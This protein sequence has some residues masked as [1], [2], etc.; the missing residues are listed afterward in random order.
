MENS[1]VTNTPAEQPEGAEATAPVGAAPTDPAGAAAPTGAAVPAGA[2]AAP[3][4]CPPYP[5]YSYGNPAYAP[6]PQ[7]PYQP[8]Y[9]APQ[10][11]QPYAPYPGCGPYVPYGYAPY[12]PY[13]PYGYAPYPYTSVPYGAYPPYPAYGY[14]P[15]PAPAPAAPGGALV[16]VALSFDNQYCYM[17]AGTLTSLLS[18]C[19]PQRRYRIHILHDDISA[20]NQLQL[21]QLAAGTPQA[22]LCFHRCDVAALAGRTLEGCGAWSRHAL[23]RLFMHRLLPQVERII[24][25]DAD[26]VVCDDIAALFDEDLQGRALGAVH[27]GGDAFRGLAFLQAAVI[28]D[29]ALSRYHS[30]YAYYT[31]GLGLADED[32]L[33]YFNSGVL[34]LDLKRAAPLLE[35]VPAALGEPRIYPDQDLLNVLFRHDKRLLDARYNVMPNRVE[36]YVVAHGCLPAV[37]HNTTPKPTRSMKGAAAA[38]YWRHIEGTVYYCQALELYF[39]TRLQAMA[40]QLRLRLQGAAAPGPQGQGR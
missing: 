16:E 26:T 19:S 11:S 32:L 8:P 25:L 9:Q 1:E 23:F 12:D 30:L 2:D 22:E 5:P 20:Y 35:Q 34:L 33:G 39:D 29:P 14:A 7:P 17:A 38:E 37:I 4:A 40:R 27:D 36:E 21:T 6:Q 24:Y 3:G 18:H 28:T 10:P 13:T 15:A 31:E